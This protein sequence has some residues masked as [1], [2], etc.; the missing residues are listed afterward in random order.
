MVITI[1]DH[2]PHCYTARDGAIIHDIIDRG[3][4]SGEKV[5]LSFS[6]VTDVPS[7]FINAALVPFVQDQ[8]L[9]WVKSNLVITGVTQQV[10]AMIRRCFANAQCA[11]EAA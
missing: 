4:R 2:V 7:S 11:L 1:L 6:G 5:T 10:A 3:F 9:G 8:G